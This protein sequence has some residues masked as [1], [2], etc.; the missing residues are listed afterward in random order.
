MNRRILSRLWTLLLLFSAIL[1]DAQSSFVVETLELESS[2]MDSSICRAP[3]LRD[4]ANVENII[5]ERINQ[6]LLEQLLLDEYEIEGAEIRW[7]DL[8]FESELDAHT[9]Y[10]KY[11]GEYYG[12]YGSRVEEELFYDLHSGEALKNIDVPFPAL[13]TLAGYL[14]FMHDFWLKGVKAAF[15]EAIECADSEPY[16]SYY[17]VSDYEFS[18][19]LLSLTLSP[20]CYPHVSR[21][22]SPDYSIEVP[23][24]SLKPFL[25]GLGELILLEQNYTQKKGLDRFYFNE[26]IAASLPQHLYLFGKID[27]RF[28]FSMALEFDVEDTVAGFYF[29]DKVRKP[30]PLDRIDDGSDP[31]ELVFEEQ[32]E[33]TVTGNFSLRGSPD[34]DADALSM[35]NNNTTVY[36]TGE[37]SNPDGTK[38]FPIKFTAWKLSY[39]LE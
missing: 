20:H 33:G 37:W 34:F 39:P 36:L 17:D 18:N 21:A 24:E 10:I 1:S 5:V 16:C 3:Q 27:G 13:F 11:T 7:A 12:A 8:S 25:S 26:K 14:D 2:I 9:L 15:K 22:C 32:A 28:P 38:R 30:L 35:S 29:Y 23:L 4:T 19:E 6:D 31:F